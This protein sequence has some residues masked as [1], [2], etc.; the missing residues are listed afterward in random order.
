MSNTNAAAVALLLFACSPNPRD[1]TVVA[2]T[3]SATT[4]I[5]APAESPPDTAWV[6]SLDRAGRFTPGM[7]LEQARTSIP[8]LDAP[9]T[10]AEGCDYASVRGGEPKLSFLI[11][12]DRLARLDVQST[13]VPTDRGIR[14][15]DTE[16]KVKAAYAGNVTVQPHKYTDGHYLVVENPSDTAI[17]LIFETDGAKVTRYRLGSKP[18]VSWVEGCS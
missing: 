14:V 15:G 12:D 18:V 16:A 7:T 1:E 11:V 13:S 8:G 2:D 5:P 3:A 17:A 4:P 10:P 9:A 6:V